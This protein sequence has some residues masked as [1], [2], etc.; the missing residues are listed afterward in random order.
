MLLYDIVQAANITTALLNYHGEQDTT[1]II[2]ALKGTNDGYSDGAPA[3]E[4]CRAYIFPN[5]S[6]GYLGAAG[7]WQAALD[8]KT[9]INSALKL[10]GGVEMSEVY[11]TC[12]QYNNVKSWYIRWHNEYF[13]ISDRNSGCGVRAFASI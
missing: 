8:N 13:E 3:A 4:Y 9:A 2:N 6:I 5:G 10:C 1:A 7:E 11:W 12:T